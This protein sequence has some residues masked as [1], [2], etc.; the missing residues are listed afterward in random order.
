MALAVL[1]HGED[2]VG[3]RFTDVPTACALHVD[4]VE[5]RM[6]AALALEVA[7]IAEPS[8]LV[9]AVVQIWGAF[10]AAVGETVRVGHTRVDRA[11]ALLRLRIVSRHWEFLLH[12]RHH[13]AWFLPPPLHGFG[14]S[15]NKANQL[16][17][18]SCRSARDTI[19]LSQNGFSKCLP[20]FSKVSQIRTEYQSVS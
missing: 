12:A 11:N 10:A 20:H 6:R 1:I 5:L 15:E 13:R 19:R 14:T 17:H 16:V 2:R 8:G 18:G 9:E 4:G 7:H 3:R